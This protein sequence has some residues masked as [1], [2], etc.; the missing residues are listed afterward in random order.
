MAR[1]LVISN[2]P[3]DRWSE[4]Q[5]KGWDSIDYIPFPDV[6][7]EADYLDVAM[8]YAKPIIE[9]IWNWLSKNP[10]GKV[11]VQ[12]EYTVCSI[13]FSFVPF[14]VFTFPTTKRVVQEIQKEDGTVEKVSVFKFVKWRQ[15]ESITRGDQ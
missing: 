15:F 14:Y 10:D 5:K 9:A 3:P 1:L 7:A 13:V 8:H 2:H 11:C 6:P 4:E 12:G